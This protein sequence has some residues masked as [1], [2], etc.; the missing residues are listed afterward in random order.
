MLK[1]Q[2]T[3]KKSTGDEAATK[4]LGMG[5]VTHCIQGE[6]SFIAWSMDVKFEGQNV[7]RHLDLM[8]HNSSVIRRT[9]HRS[10]YVDRMAMMKDES[11]C[12]TE[13]DN[14][15]THCGEPP[16]KEKLKCPTPPVTDPY[17]RA[18]HEAYATGE[19]GTL[20]G[21][22]PLRTDLLQK[23]Q[24]R[25]LLSGSDTRSPDRGFFLSQQS[26]GE[27]SHVTGGG[28]MIRTPHRACAPRA[29]TKQ[30]RRMA[31]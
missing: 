20:P 3:F 8:L 31:T 25:R 27:A 18:E 12:Q 11:D 14:V 24:G 9:R 4:S 13:R 26:Q 17:S 15:N 10:F 30:W 28:T 16:S 29:R 23:G 2:S 21:C 6:A 19:Q 1:D 5:V 22:T 7:D